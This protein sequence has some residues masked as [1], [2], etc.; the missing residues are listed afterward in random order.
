MSEQ[1]MRDNLM[2]LAEKFAEATGWSIATISKKIHGKSTFFE[3]YGAGEQTTRISHYFLMVNRFRA[4]WP[5][6]TRWPTTWPV[7]K[8]GRKVDEGFVDAE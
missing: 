4:R 6:G 1:I 2:K 3:E 7:E 5:K 8:L